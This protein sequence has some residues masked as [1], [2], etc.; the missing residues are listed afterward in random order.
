MCLFPTKQGF[1]CGKCIDCLSKKRNDWSI[2]LQYE[3]EYWLKQDCLTYMVLLTYDPEHAPRTKQGNLT[4]RKRDV[5]L[6]MK[7]LRKDF[8][9][10]NCFLRMFYCGEYGPTTLRPHYHMLLFG[11]PSSISKRDVKILLEKHW[12]NGFVGDKLGVATARGIHYCTKYMINKIIKLPNDDEIEKPFTQMSKGLGMSYLFDVSQDKHGLHRLAKREDVVKRLNNLDGVNLVDMY[13]AA[14]SCENEAQAVELSKQIQSVFHD[15][16]TVNGTRFKLPRYY[17]DRVFDGVTRYL[18]N[19]A[20][21]HLFHR[22]NEIE[23]LNKYGEYDKT[24]EVPMKLLMAQEKTAR[25]VGLYVKSCKD[26]DKI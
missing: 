19:F 5:Q 8:T 24:H 20:D 2:R 4:L 22:L 1:P 14:R 3:R 12:Q 11:I 17:R 6:F 26:K 23:Y 25:L 18:I 21:Y 10:R 7:R 9:K 15:R 16:V 13:E